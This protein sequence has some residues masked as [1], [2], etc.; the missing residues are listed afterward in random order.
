[1]ARFT[2]EHPTGV[3]VEQLESLVRMAVF[4]PANALV[5]F[6]LQQAADRIDASYQPK[7][8]QHYK[9]RERLGVRGMFGEFVMERADYYDPEK[10]Q[11]HYPAD[12][13]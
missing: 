9:G 8:G 2:A 13:A 6:L 10:N 3:A 5:G 7:P 11:G 1:M 12:A 4:R